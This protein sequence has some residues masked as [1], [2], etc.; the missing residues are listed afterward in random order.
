MLVHKK[1]LPLDAVLH[2][3]LALT[4]LAVALGVFAE[5]RAPGNFLVSAFRSFSLTM[6][7][8]WMIVVSTSSWSEE[9]NAQLQEITPLSTEIEASFACSGIGTVVPL[10]F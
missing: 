9:Q 7:G 4:M 8:L 6:H 10:Q 1:H 2:N 3:T 5:L